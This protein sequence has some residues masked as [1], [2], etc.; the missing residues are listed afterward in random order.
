MKNV[1]IASMLTPPGFCSTIA[2]YRGL[3]LFLLYVLVFFTIVAIQR[4][5]RG[6]RGSHRHSA[7]PFLLCCAQKE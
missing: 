1:P 7:D 4:G 5:V 6:E 3:A 2:A